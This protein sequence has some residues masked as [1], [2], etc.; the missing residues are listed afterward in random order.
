MEQKEKVLTSTVGE[1]VNDR[2]QRRR[3]MVV[4]EGGW[5]KKGRGG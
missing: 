1:E 3:R 4:E 5:S 2:E